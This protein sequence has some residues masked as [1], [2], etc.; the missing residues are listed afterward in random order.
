M[1][2]Y[3]ISNIAKQTAVYKIVIY[4]I[5]NRVIGEDTDSMKIDDEIGMIGYMTF[6]N[7][8]LNKSGKYKF[9][10]EMLYNKEFQTVAVKTLYVE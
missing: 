2:Y 10:L 3:S 4:D 6:E 7:L 1:V 8:D 9:D 5:N